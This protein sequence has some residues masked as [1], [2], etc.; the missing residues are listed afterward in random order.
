MHDRP[1]ILELEKNLSA[2]RD[3]TT[4][5]RLFASVNGVVQFYTIGRKGF[6]KSVRVFSFCRVKDSTGKR[7]DGKET[8]AD[9]ESTQ[10]FS[11]NKAQPLFSNKPEVMKRKR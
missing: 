4:N 8:N 11:G 7:G 6:K 2:S 5:I 1:I 10:F 3:S 9:E